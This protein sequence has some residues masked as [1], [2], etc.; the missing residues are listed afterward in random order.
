MKIIISFITYNQSSFQYLPYFLP[1]LNEAI[2]KAKKKFE[3]KIEIFL[4]VFDNSTNSFEKNKNFLLNFFNDNKIEYK[5]WSNQGNLGFAKA[6]NIM[7]NY[8]IKNNFDKFIM[9]NPDVLLDEYFLEKFIFKFKQYP[10]VAVLSPS[11]FYWDFLNNKKT[12]IIDSCGL[13]LT[14]SHYFFDRGQGNFRKS[15]FEKEEEIFGFTGAG[16]GLDLKKI[17]QVAYRKEN[18]Y[19]EFF[20]ELMFMYKEDVELSYRLQLANFKIFFIPEIKMYHHRT[21]S[22]FNNKIKSI[23]LKSNSNL[24]RSRSFLNQLIIIYK[25]KRLPFS[26]K[27]KVLTNFRVFLIIIYGL[28]FQSKQFKEFKRIK[29]SIKTK[30]LYLKDNIKGVGRVERFMGRY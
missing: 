10:E 27:V 24:N 5:I 29:A 30:P 21:M 12:N 7:L 16:A 15:D 18:N 4:L 26:F 22:S 3:G 1:S 9:V 6:Y 23:F 2:E 25:I 14:K 13:G 11:I 17:S 8:S 20:D 19:L 28:F